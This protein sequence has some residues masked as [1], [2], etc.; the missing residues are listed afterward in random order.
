MIISNKQFS[1]TYD[2]KKHIVIFKSVR[3]GAIDF[4]SGR[5]TLLLFSSMYSLIFDSRTSRSL[6]NNFDRQINCIKFHRLIVKCKIILLISHFGAQYPADCTIY[7][8]GNEFNFKV[9]YIEM[10]CTKFHRLITKFRLISP[11]SQLECITSL[12]R[13]TAT[14][15]NWETT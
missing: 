15:A 4:I 6:R 1:E 8:L 7:H 11:I 3:G 5:D 14:L 2:S 13:G 12:K 9:R 10:I